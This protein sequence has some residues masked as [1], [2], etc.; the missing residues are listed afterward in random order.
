MANIFTRYS[1]LLLA[2]ALLVVP[3]ALAE[4]NETSTLTGTVVDQQGGLIQDASILA[5]N[6]ETGSE[7]VAKTDESGTWEITP[8]PAGSYTVIIEA[9][10]FKPREFPGIG[11]IPWSA[12]TRFEKHLGIRKQSSTVNDTSWLT[13][14]TESE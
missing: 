13:S 8:V 3:T 2:L 14:R 11:S 1:Y 12:E 6:D 7:F 5:K 9:L 4:S 10:N